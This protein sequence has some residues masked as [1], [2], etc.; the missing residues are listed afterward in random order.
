MIFCSSQAVPTHYW[1]SNAAFASQKQ[2]GFKGILF[3]SSAWTQYRPI[4]VA[5]HTSP[6]DYGHLQGWPGKSCWE[7]HRGPPVRRPCPLPHGSQ[8]KKHVWWVLQ[9]LYEKCIQNEQL[10]HVLRIITWK[11][12][13]TGSA[14]FA[15]IGGRRNFISLS[16]KFHMILGMALKKLLPA[17]FK[18]PAYGNL[19]GD[20]TPYSKVYPQPLPDLWTSLHSK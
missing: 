12:E 9:P 4:L 5:W 19:M 2:R 17:W 11:S 13:L 8:F 3:R 14:A 7:V 18:G 15:G 10:D 6:I 16:G 1:V 20:V